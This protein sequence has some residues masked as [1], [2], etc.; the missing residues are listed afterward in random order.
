MSLN[1]ILTD[2]NFRHLINKFAEQNITTETIPSLSADDFKILGVDKLG[3]I[4]AIRFKCRP[5]Q[6]SNTTATAN[7]SVQRRQNILAARNILRVPPTPSKIKINIVI[8][9]DR[10]ESLEINFN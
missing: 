9:D 5:N 1:K 3:D 7:L 2:L 10:V 6:L 8:I 4:S